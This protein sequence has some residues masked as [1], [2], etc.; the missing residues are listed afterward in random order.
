MIC[1]SCGSAGIFYDRERGELICTSCGLVIYDR[2]PAEG[3]GKRW[4]EENITWVDQTRHDLGIGSEIGKT[5]NPSP[6][7]RSQM[8]RLK[9][10]H[11]ISK[12]SNW[13]ERGERDALIEIDNL[14]RSLS[15][16]RSVKVEACVIYRKARS[17]KLTKGRD[18]RIVVPVVVLLACRR[19]KIP[20]SE[21]EIFK[22]AAQRHPFEKKLVQK[23]F[24]KFLFAFKKEMKIE[25]GVGVE[26]YLGRFLTQLNASGSTSE[27]AMKLFKKSGPRARAR[28]PAN[29]SAAIIY[30]AAKISGEKMSIRRISRITGVSVSSISSG[31]KFV[32]KLLQE[33]Q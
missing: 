26:D 28:P 8:R 30:L 13:K 24:R 15:L 7:F 6:A 33:Q 17:M 12:V 18:L 25:D 19:L 22:I 11:R 23:I 3:S 31:A 4:E 5:D 29:L 20:R 27:I 9:Y 1:P 16:P 14:C 10:L 2:M 32:E 21:K